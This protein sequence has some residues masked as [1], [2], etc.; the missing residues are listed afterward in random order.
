M[1]EL[2]IGSLGMLAIIIIALISIGFSYLNKRTGLGVLFLIFG[3]VI[4]F[5]TYKVYEWFTFYETSENVPYS[6]I[7]IN[8]KCYDPIYKSKHIHVYV[9]ARKLRNKKFIT[10]KSKTYKNYKIRVNPGIHDIKFCGRKDFGSFSLNLDGSLK[11][12]A[13]EGKEIELELYLGNNRSYI[14]RILRYYVAPLVIKAKLK[15]NNTKNPLSDVNFNIQTNIDPID[16]PTNIEM[17]ISKQFKTTG[18][19][20]LLMLLR[21]EDET[22]Y[23]KFTKEGYYDKSIMLETTKKDTIFLSDIYMLSKDY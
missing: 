16:D 23:L 3:V 13:K 22:L 11:V 10:S 15:N 9:G 6:T 14:R 21:P 19:F 12:D 8:C 20:E 1:Y 2:Q 17:Y 5:F 7:N 4:I 18:I